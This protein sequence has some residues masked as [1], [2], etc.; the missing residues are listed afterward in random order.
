MNEKREILFHRNMRI[1]FDQFKKK[2]Q[3]FRT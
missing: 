3:P 1:D 2:M